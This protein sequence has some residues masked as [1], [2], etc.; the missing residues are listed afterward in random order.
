MEETIGIRRIVP[1]DIFDHIA[2]EIASL[3][4][5]LLI[6]KLLRDFVLERH[7]QY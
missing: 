4:N 2:A 1:L 6:E 5:L 3:R 7:I